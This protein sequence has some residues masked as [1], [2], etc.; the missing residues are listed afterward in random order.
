VA[1]IHTSENDRHPIGS[2]VV[3][4][5]RRVLTCAHVVR[6]ENTVREALWVAFPMYQGNFTA[7]RRVAQVRLPTMADFLHVADVAV[8]ELAEEVPAGILPAP[9]RSPKLDQITALRWWAYGF[10]GGDPIGDSAHGEISEV[11]GFGWVRLRTDKDSSYR[12]SQGFSGGGLWCPEYQAVIG[13]VAQANQDG[14]G[15]AIT[16]FQIDR[17]MPEEKLLELATWS[18]D[19]AGEAALAAWGW[20]LSI[21]PEAGR[22]WRPR[23]RGV[24]RES[25]RGFR[26][27][28]RTAALTEIRDWLDADRVEP[29]ALVVTGDPGA[30]KSAVLGRI[31]TTADP[32]IR[33]ELPPD[34]QAV[35]A[36]VGS[37]AC[38]V[39]AKGKTALD[40][41]VEIARAASAPLPS[42]VDELVPAIRETLAERPGRRFTVIIDAL[43]EVAG[44][45]EAR[46]VISR[47]VLPLAEAC[48][49]V[50][51]RVVVGTRRHD[52]EGDLLREFAGRCKI[53]DL[54]SPE[55]FSIDDLTAYALATLQ[56]A[57]DERPGNPYL[58]DAVAGPVARR[59]AELSERNFLVAG[60]IAR[61]HGLHDHEPVDPDALSF[62][63]T[64]DEALHRYVARLPA[65]AGV[66]AQAVLTALAFAEAPGLP[67]RLWKA[68]ISALGEGTVSEQALQHFARSSAANFL[69]E[70]G[71]HRTEP[72][73]RLFHQ[74][75]NDAL[76]HLRGQRVP[77]FTDEAALT[78]AFHRIGADQEWRAVPAY[79][80]GS[81]PAHAARAGMI[82]DLLL[83]DEYLLHAD[84]RRL[85]FFAGHATSPE[86]RNRAR[87]LRLTHQAA[88]ASPIDRA[89]MFT[90]TEA[91]YDLGDG[92]RRTTRDLP[93][94][95]EWASDAGSRDIHMILKGHS[96]RLSAVCAFT[97]GGRLLLAS[98]GDDGVVRVW[99]PRTGQ[100]YRML[101]GHR[102][103]VR[104]VCAFTL[105]GR[106]LLAGAA[107]DRTVRIWD[108]LS[109]RQEH[110]FEGH[111]RRVRSVCA[112]TLDGRTLL[113]SASADRTVRIWDPA[114][115][116]ER[117]ILRDL[118]DWVYAV[119]ALPPD[120]GALLATA[121]ADG[122]VRVWNPATG[123]RRRILKGHTDLTRSVC[124][125]TS[126]GRTFLASAGNDATVCVWDAR[127]GER[128]HLLEGHTRRVRSVCAFTLGGHTL[129]ASASADGTVRIWDPVTGYRLRTLSGHTRG[130]REVCALELGGHTLLATVAEDLTLRVWEPRTGVCLA[131]IDVPH[132]GWTVAWDG[133]RLA[134][135]TSAGLLTIRPLPPLL[136][137]RRSLF[138]DPP[139][140]PYD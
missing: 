40:V 12:V 99:D 126:G 13:L 6:P 22:H 38:A 7:W 41:A 124:A 67:L 37:V 79:L 63:P 17:C 116:T 134:I 104:S 8:L 57:G 39:H 97:L 102:R 113:A 136:D 87:L 118:G 21:D 3:V 128:H 100:Q 106:T 24:T 56:L 115:G 58:D 73:F 88:T 55:Y 4:D 84:L 1:A 65:V 72:V 95:A 125:F 52:D 123:R 129:L 103:K 131:A 127:T 130:V 23:A 74:A 20:E 59:I 119:C 96:G 26:F 133:E 101:E 78:K 82:D 60:L 93:Y 91:V 80:L 10:P 46:S 114:T 43:D 49:D 31:I 117:R 85:L 2:G 94:K 53:I 89:A 68:A 92:F 122:T 90:I 50:G 108:P 86:G 137:D 42:D 44:P 9:L 111:R 64:R 66:S 5:T 121:A 71:E 33:R 107:E 25:E 54:D 35:K 32:A 75:L 70:S 30:G 120:E 27:R 140:D 105:D 45:A 61:Y 98:G 19:Q 11:L 29:G 138:G 81:L 83:D 76:V 18:A 15:R 48:A 16:L 69:I 14:D 51:A 112:F 47:I 28:G 36:S 34:D 139:G 132:P 109:G 77:R 62:S 135:G 110:V